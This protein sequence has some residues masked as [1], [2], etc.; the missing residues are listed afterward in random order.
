M[1]EFPGIWVISH[2]RFRTSGIR[3]VLRVLC[4]LK[5][6]GRC[7]KNLEGCMVHQLG[8]IWLSM[9]TK[10]WREVFFQRIDLHLE[11]IEAWDGLREVLGTGVRI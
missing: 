8:S 5:C 9:C 6:L 10:L 1:G 11:Q 3:R 2:T 7:P 4:F